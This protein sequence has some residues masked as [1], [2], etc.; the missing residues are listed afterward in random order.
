MAPTGPLRR[1][2]SQFSESQSPSMSRVWPQGARHAAEFHRR[3]GYGR[4][5]DRGWEHLQKTMGFLPK[6]EFL[7]ASPENNAGCRSVLP[8]TDLIA[9]IESR[10]SSEWPLLA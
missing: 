4:R 5:P 7:I 1:S 2:G 6:P 3:S 8:C 9:T 10:A